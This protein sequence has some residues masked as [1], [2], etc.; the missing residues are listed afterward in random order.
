M[1][2]SNSSGNPKKIDKIEV[3]GQNVTIYSDKKQI[4][5]FYNSANENYFVVFKNENK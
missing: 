3:I 2:I 4:D 5:S 1:P